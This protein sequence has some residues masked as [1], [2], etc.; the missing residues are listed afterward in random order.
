MWVYLIAGIGERFAA[1]HAGTRQAQPG[2]RSNGLVGSGRDWGV[3]SS[4]PCCAVL[5]TAFQT[6]WQLRNPFL[7]K[8]TSR[9]E[10]RVHPKFLVG[11]APDCGSQRLSFLRSR[12]WGLRSVVPLDEWLNRWSSAV[13]Q[14]NLPPQPALVTRSTIRRVWTATKSAD[15]T[16]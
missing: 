6:L 7:G 2:R 10:M 14:W 5:Q 15:S 4:E 13:R 8:Y 1:C 11:L 12:A 9:P 16:I 3:L